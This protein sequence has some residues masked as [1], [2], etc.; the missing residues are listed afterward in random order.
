MHSSSATALADPQSAQDAG[1][2]QRFRDVRAFSEY[3][4]APLET[5]D[6][7][8]QPMADAS[9]MKWHLAHTTWFFETFILV[10]HA[11]GYEV[12]HPEYAYLF[13]SYYNTLGAQFSR[14][15]RGLITRPTVRQTLEYRRY[16][17]EHLERFLE[18]E[19]PE[20]VLSLVE[21]GLHHE[22]Q[23]QELMV[24]DLKYLLSRNPLFPVYRPATEPAAG[25]P[26]DLEWHPHEEGLRHLG[27]DGE[28]FAFD[29]EGPRH[30]VF[31][32]SFEIASRL[33]TNGEF[34]EFMGDGGYE[35]AAPWLS[36]GWST[37]QAEG[38][39]APL[40]WFEIDGE[41]QHFTLAGLRPVDPR[42]PVCHVSFYEADA[43]AR[44]AGARLPGEAE[45]ELTC[46]GGQAPVVEGAN[47]VDTGRFHPT[48]GAFSPTL[49]GPPAQ[50]LG[51][52][53]EWTSS[54]Y[55]CY[56]GYQPPPGALGEY[57]AKFMSSQMILRGGSCATSASHIRPTYRN[58]FQPEKRWQMTGLRL[59]RDLR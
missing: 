50:L 37:V 51:D 18:G 23:H 27:F 17:N 11:P 38:W 8:V 29:N 10:P 24:T 20:E 32:E 42:E 55:G 49:G 53:W 34:L 52:V 30:R 45:W 44:W 40:Y 56:P 47:F 6:Y 22:Q 35:R 33:V 25:E 7:V 13:N 9:P 14:P 41:W 28:G 54:P 15:D 1:M 59:A 5:E 43:F 48:P 26:A 31:V 58:F 39:R 21:V 12:L 2:L 4:C 16:V 36:D 19:P 3:L 57:N 46:T